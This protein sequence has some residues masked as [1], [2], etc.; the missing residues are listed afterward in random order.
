MQADAAPVTSLTLAVRARRCGIGGGPGLP[1]MDIDIV[2]RLLFP[3]PPSSY[4]IDSFSGELIWV[5]R[6]LNPQTSSP[7]DCIPCLFL[8]C[9]A[10]KYLLIYLHGNAEDIG[11][12]YSFCKAS[13]DSF[14]MHVLAV[15]YPGYGICPGDRCDERGATESALTA[16]RFVREVL[17]WP[18][19]HIMILGRSI[20]TGP[21][22]A[23]AAEHH[24][25]GLILVSPFLSVREVCRDALG[26]IAYLIEER[27]PNRERIALVRSPLLVV[28][29]LADAM[30]PDRHG[31]ELYDACSS[32]KSLVLPPDMDHN[33]NLIED[34]NFFVEPM[35]AFFVLPDSGGGEMQV[36]RWAFDK[37][38]SPQFFDLQVHPRGSASMLWACATCTGCAR[39]GAVQASGQSRKAFVA[40]QKV[41][42]GRCGGSE[43]STDGN[44]HVEET[45]TCA[46][47]HV[48]SRKED[49]VWAEAE[50]AGLSTAEELPPQADRGAADGQCWAP[51]GG[52]CSGW[53]AGGGESGSAMTPD[54]VFHHVATE[55]TV[56]YNEDGVLVA[57]VRRRSQAVALAPAPKAKSGSPRKG[58]G[59]LV[60]LDRGTRAGGASAFPSQW[61]NSFM[62]KIPSAKWRRS[63]EAAP[64]AQAE[65]VRI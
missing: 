47:E 31:R 2:S 32:R 42:D 20:G 37:R 50:D 11:R 23:L 30:I 28:H 6:S 18:L 1:D 7:E 15:E 16:F 14:Q 56:E 10:A 36:P 58:G 8:Q 39:P 27:F 51:A 22:V 59:F 40:A 3:A 49:F 12:C 34:P 41:V 9:P 52:V 62:C 64:V 63:R 65:V 21:A 54:S 48:L 13:R 4:G 25:S 44:N 38:L 35:I 61:A 17:R 19:D 24:V 55:E 26:P 46:V 53:T 57:D 29:G 60:P 43:P 33:A 5:P 45:I